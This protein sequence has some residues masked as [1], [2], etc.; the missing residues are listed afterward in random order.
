[1]ESSSSRSGRLVACWGLVRIKG[2]RLFHCGKGSYKYRKDVDG[3]RL[4][5]EIGVNSWFLIYIDMK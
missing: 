5:L 2:A 4:K 1:M 3:V